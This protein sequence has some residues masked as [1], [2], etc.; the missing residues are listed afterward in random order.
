[1]FE[2]SHYA[3][4][5]S[6]ICK[7]H[8]SSWIS[9]INK[10]LR[11]ILIL[12]SFTRGC[13]RKKCKQ[14][15]QN[16]RRHHN[17]EMLQCTATASRKVLKTVQSTERFRFLSLF[18]ISEL[19]INPRDVES[20]W[21]FYKFVCYEAKPPDELHWVM[22]RCEQQLAMSQVRSN[23]QQGELSVHSCTTSTQQSMHKESTSAF[24]SVNHSSYSSKDARSLQIQQY[25]ALV[26][27][28]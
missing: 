13:K 9:E 6:I 24:K 16:A 12:Q 20:L 11:D 18:L 5:Q 15:E 14:A 28:F 8:L 4:N 23:T 27:R 1:M 3:C 7:F 22:A 2:I 26:K 19:R 25:D 17:R 21:C 10:L